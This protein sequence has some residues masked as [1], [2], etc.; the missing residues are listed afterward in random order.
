[1]ENCV[2]HSIRHICEPYNADRRLQWSSN[3]STD[4]DYGV[5]RISVYIILI[6]LFTIK[7]ACKTR[8]K[9]DHRTVYQHGCPQA[10][11]AEICLLSLFIMCLYK[12]GVDYLARILKQGTHQLSFKWLNT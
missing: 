12:I 10:Y 6:V 1:M 2:N 9:P 5:P 3:I 11:F 7:A 4:H 8:T